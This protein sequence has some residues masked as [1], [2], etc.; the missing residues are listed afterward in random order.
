MAKKRNVMFV[1]S[2][3]VC[4][5]P[6][7]EAVF[8]EIVKQNHVADKWHIES[9]GTRGRFVGRRL[10]NRIVSV[11]KNHGIQFSHKSQML[12]LEHFYMFDFILAMTPKILR[13]INK[14]KPE[15]SIAQT[16]FLGSFNPE[17]SNMTIRNPFYDTYIQRF[18]K[19]FKII[20]KLCN[21]FLAKNK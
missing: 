5:S 9:S 10:D 19:C 11:L 4:Q 15:E 3:N 21:E 6:M 17:G 14:I 13:E 16:L 18:E 1:C 7:A 2:T 20:M 12:Q 8:K